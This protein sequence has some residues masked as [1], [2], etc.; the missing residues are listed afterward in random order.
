[1]KPIDPQHLRLLAEQFTYELNHADAKLCRDAAD[2]I[3]RL[4]KAILLSELWHHAPCVL[5]GYNGPGYFQ[6]RDHWCVQEA[7]D[8]ER[9]AVRDGRE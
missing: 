7:M 2:E 8:A 9:E 6:S 3:E 1:M 5:C 4:R